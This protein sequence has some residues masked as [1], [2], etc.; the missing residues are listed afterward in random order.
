[1]TPPADPFIRLRSAMAAAERRP[2]VT[3]SYAQSMDGCL[4]LH[5]GKDAPVSGA[6]S[7]LITHRLRAMHEAI[8]VG[9]G[10]LLADDPRLTAHRVGGPHPRPVV[11]DS[12]LR[13]PPGARLFD[14]PQTPI[15][16]GV[17]PLDVDRREGLEVAGAEVLGLPAGSD[18]RVALGALLAALAERDIGSVMVEGGAE[19][20][21][22]FLRCRWVD[23][24]V[25]TVAPVWAG[26]YHAVGD[27]GATGWGEL[28]R[29]R[30]VICQPAGEDLTVWG[31]VAQGG[32]V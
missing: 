32:D 26:G 17:A 31:R 20:I 30:E 10:T 12:R 2:F 16:A 23:Y 29:L 15:I 9:I 21:T 5:R 25:V 13:C 22:A 27:L 8:L 7:K 3:L 14:H 28:P 11:L 24:A 19:V 4:T 6:A 18:G 1:M